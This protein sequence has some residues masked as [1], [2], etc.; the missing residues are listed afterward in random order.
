MTEAEILTQLEDLIASF[1]AIRRPLALDADL[2]EDVE[3]DSVKT[4]ALT[5]EVESHFQ[6][7]IDDEDAYEIR[8]VGDLVSCVAAQLPKPGV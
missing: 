4:L 5:V 7:A 6:I 8:T 3:L 2:I 1:V